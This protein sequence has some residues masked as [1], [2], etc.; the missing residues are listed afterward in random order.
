MDSEISEFI[1]WEAPTTVMGFSMGGGAALNSGANVESVDMYNI[2]LA[3]ALPPLTEQA[4][5]DNNYP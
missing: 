2:G 1:D 3:V 4:M 5:L